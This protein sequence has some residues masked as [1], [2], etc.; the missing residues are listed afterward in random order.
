MHPPAVC[1]ALLLRSRYKNLSRPQ[2]QLVP[3][4]T[5]VETP[6]SGSDT[7]AKLIVTA[8]Q[9]AGTGPLALLKAQATVAFSVYFLGSD[10]G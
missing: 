2:M 5:V 8:A 7:A 4:S 3:Q 9:D 1:F 6:P 10:R